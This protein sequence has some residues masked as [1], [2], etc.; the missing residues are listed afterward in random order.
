[1][2]TSRI[3]LL[4]RMPIFGGIRADTLTALLEET[5]VRRVSVGEFFFRQGEQAMFMYV[6][7]AGQVTVRKSWRGRELVLGTLGD[8]DCFGEMALI[9]MSLRSASVRA[10]R[11]CSAIEISSAQLY[12]IYEYDPEQ[13]TIIQM[14]ISRELSRRLRKTDEHL[15]QLL[16]HRLVTEDTQSFSELMAM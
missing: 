2:N 3:E 13:F 6:L 16:D 5:R 10:E 12:G 7:E 9:D 15:M 11:L 8:G 14:N 4:Q 1:M